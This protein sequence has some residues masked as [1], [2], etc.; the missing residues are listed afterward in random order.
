M[1]THLSKD[2]YIIAIWAIDEQAAAEIWRNVNLAITER[3][4]IVGYSCPGL[5]NRNQVAI[6]VIDEGD[7]ATERVGQCLQMPIRVVVGSG[8]EVGRCDL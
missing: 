7:H 6:A 1:Q 4:P 5:S 8:N 3:G 2:G